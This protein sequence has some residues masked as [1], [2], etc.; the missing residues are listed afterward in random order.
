MAELKQKRKENQEEMYAD[1]KS[2]GEAT[3]E[4]MKQNKAFQSSETDYI[5]A[6]DA[7]GN[8]IVVLGKHNSLSQVKAVA[9]RLLDSRLMH[10]VDTSRNIGKARTDELR[11]FLNK[12]E[13]ATSFLAIPG[14]QSYAPQ[15]G[16]IFG[17]LKQMKED[18]ESL[19][20]AKEDEIATGQKLI[21][22]LD[23]SIADTQE[24]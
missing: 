12:A 16:Q 7:A 3:E 18:Y 20:A 11:S 14:M 8:A 6:I 23:G 13:T 15:S 5:E 21:V 10:M 1:Q 22:S 4:R 2:L 17:I 19:K 24:K 9:H